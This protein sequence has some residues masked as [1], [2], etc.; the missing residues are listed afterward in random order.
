M[1]LAVERVGSL[2]DRLLAM[3][4]RLISSS[5]NLEISPSDQR[6]LS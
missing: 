6:A 1:R 3:R 4:C 2:L 5:P